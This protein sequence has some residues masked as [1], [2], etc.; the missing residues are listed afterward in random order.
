M[1]GAT[2]EP[3][4]SRISA[5]RPTTNTT[6]GVIHQRLR[7]GTQRGFCRVVGADRIA[8]AGAKF[9]S[10][11]NAEPAASCQIRASPRVRMNASI[12]VSSFSVRIG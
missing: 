4:V 5:T 12:A 6:M 9:H 2:A 7:I 3:S 1:N 10:R 8:A 11:A